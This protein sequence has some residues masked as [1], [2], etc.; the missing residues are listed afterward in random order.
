MTVKEKKTRKLSIMWFSCER[1]CKLTVLH[2]FNQWVFSVGFKIDYDHCHFEVSGSFYTGF[3]F[4][5]KCLIF[6]WFHNWYDSNLLYHLWHTKKTTIYLD[7]YIWKFLFQAQNVVFQTKTA[8][9]PNS[10]NFPKK[11]KTAS[12]FIRI[13]KLILAL[14]Y[15]IIYLLFVLII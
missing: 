11:K 1:I 3:Y 7:E 15:K 13:D 6:S 8:Q 5:C 9:K 4:R 2:W 10:S 12:H 14:S